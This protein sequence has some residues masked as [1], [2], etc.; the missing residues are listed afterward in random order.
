MFRG[1]AV[2]EAE[3]WPHAGLLAQQP[4][5]QALAVR[6]RREMGDREAGRRAHPAARLTVAWH[7]TAAA[8]RE[9]DRIT[10]P[11]RL[12]ARAARLGCGIGRFEAILV[13]AV[14]G[15]V[16]RPLTGCAPRHEGSV[17][18]LLAG[19][20]VPLVPKSPEAETVRRNVARVGH[21][22]RCPAAVRAAFAPARHPYVVAPLGMGLRVSGTVHGL[23]P[24]QAS[25]DAVDAEM[26]QGF[27]TALATVYER[28]ALRLQLAEQRAAMHAA[29]TAAAADPGSRPTVACG[30][31]ATIIGTAEG[32]LSP[33]RLKQ[34]ARTL[35]PRE[36]DIL[37]LMALGASNVQ[38]GTELG[39]ATYTV[40]YHAKNIYRKLRVRT[41]AAAAALCFDV[42]PPSDRGSRVGAS[43]RAC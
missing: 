9:L 11:A 19:P 41:R 10:D 33:A 42:P 43:G 31:Q 8:M 27:A 18:R 17:A 35:T 14:D 30:P 34:L 28:A 25:A 36:M 40:K 5:A 22:S 16:L 3:A 12:L 38:I 39:I 4:A 37:R 6:L 13:S 32:S 7:A 1:G 24:A 21:P 20:T 15:P 2:L 29:L 26:L 23:L